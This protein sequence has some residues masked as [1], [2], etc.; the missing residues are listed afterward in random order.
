MKFMDFRNRDTGSK[1]HRLR[2]WA[3]GICCLGGFLL[4]AAFFPAAQAQAVYGSIFGTVT[5]PS[6]A[7]IPNA[8]VTITDVSKG[9]TVV[10]QSNATGDYR[11]DHLIPDIYKISV[12]AGG[13]ETSAVPSVTLY[14]DTAPKVDVTLRPGATSSTV[15]VTA[16]APLLQTDRADVSTILDERSVENLPNLNRNFTEFELL[17]PGT[18]YIGWN[19][20]QADNPQQSE[21]IE[22][23]GQLPFATGYELDG[24]DNQDPVIGVA[25]INPNLDAVSEMKVTSQNYDAEFGKAVG[26]LVTAQTRSGGNGLHGSAFEFR[27]S[28]AQQ[29]RDPFTQ[30]A[31]DPLTGKFIPPYLF[32]QFGGSLGGPVKRDKLFYFGDYQGLR[33][34][35][36]TTVITTV[37]TALA[38]TSCTSGSNCDLSDYLNPAM[39]GGSIYQAYDP[40]SNPNGTAGRAA[41][42]GNVIPAGRLSTPAVNLMKLMP[43]PNN[44]TNIV[45]NYLASG[46]GGFNTDQFDVRA[47]D[48][49]ISQK[50][51]TFA[52]YTRFDS[53]LD[54]APFFGAAGGL[55]FGAGD[56]AGTD[57]ALDQSVAAGGDYAL[58][59]KWLTDFRF[60]WFRIYLNEEGPNYNQPLGT[61]LGIPGVNQG[62]L[63]LNG[64]LPQFNINIPN[65]GSNGGANL[66]FGTSTNQ[67]LQTEN[68][69]QGVNNWTRVAGNHTIKFGADLRYA[70]NHLVGL[71]NNQV[72][73]GNFSFLSSVTE[74]PSSSGLG[75]ATFLLGDVS[76]LNRTVTQNTNAQERQRRLFFYGQDEWRATQRLTLNYGLRWEMYFPESVTGKGQGGLLDLNTGNI[77]IA[78]YG[79]WG[80]NLNVAMD[81]A[82][83]APRV[84]VAYELNKNTVF[85][86]GY[87][88]EYGMGWSGDIFGEVLTFSYPTQVN[89]NL[90][91][92]SASYYAFN[93]SQ[94][95]PPYSFPAIP[96][97]GNYPL[98][99][100][101]S[102]PTRPLTMR[103]PTLDTWNA[104]LQQQFGPGTSLQIGYVGSHGIHNMFDSSNQASPN[105]PTI[106]GFDCSSAPVGCT[107]PIDP[108][109]GVAYT[110][111]ER[112]PYY[113]GTAQADLGLPYGHPFGWTQDLRYNA[114]E[115]TTSYQ[116]LQVVFQKQYSKGFQLQ[117]NYTWSHARAHESDYYFNDPSADYGNSY[118]NRRNVFIV[119][120]NWDLPF[121]RQ[122][123][124]GS[125]VPGWMNQIIGGFTLNGDLSA[126]TGLP[127]TPSYSLCTEDQDI[128][129]QGGSMC[130]PNSV[131]PAA[132]FGLH[133][134]AFDPVGHDVR[135][136]SALPTLAYA[137]AQEG[138]YVRP[139]PGHFGDI[140]RDAL[141]GPGLF[142]TDL[143]VAKKFFLTERL[144]FQFMAQ[145]FNVFNHPSLGQPSGCVD[146]GPS[147]GLITDIVASQDGTT[148][149][150]L[151]FSGRFQF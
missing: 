75:F 142:N 73:S 10:V 108:T 92:P 11:V 97:D 40:E 150:R 124:V 129:G 17:T 19:V 105:Q 35:T 29:A 20:G 121:G 53:S 30:F 38:H 118:Y 70:M 37:P 85:R 68:Q 44:G 34:K 151:Q 82:H 133:A 134:G 21:Q 99:D 18:S 146:C 52:R 15:Q 51:H 122:R 9:T 94:G 114:N 47:D 102:V 123:A 86:A 46:S 4:A 31:P 77:R 2:R 16:A 138:P 109:T 24:T 148:M 64:G 104:M 107:V 89:Q 136:F 127:F 60:G 106:A 96:S 140:Q 147:S 28:D 128:D 87:G 144:N 63:A 125:A 100:G 22:V 65:N 45:N 112:R 120:G 110:Q 103:I 14:A 57:S 56:F 116:A 101:I 74:G 79:P 149:R 3:C 71:N 6:G 145:A 23:N 81:W 132:D 58:S 130:R 32:N 43:M 83:L 41:F 78:G 117:S 72:R 76:S 8:T 88:R 33:E 61:Q 135:Y 49:L 55:G 50:F 36:G 131:G 126:E 141:W 139:L 54:G 48:Q 84:G 1:P 66:E 39:E 137:G 93:L 111:D 62:N 27:R 42:A 115:A 143:S 98:P 12:A 90:N 95:P 67:F 25:V 59:A 7:V 80:N 91:A 5:D 26:G 69:L 13:F 119:D 113:D